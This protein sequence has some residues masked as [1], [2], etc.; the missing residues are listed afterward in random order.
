MKT[1]VRIV[2]CCT[3][4]MSYAGLSLAGQFVVLKSMISS[5]GESAIDSEMGK[6]SPPDTKPFWTQRKYTAPALHAGDS[7]ALIGARAPYC[8]PAPERL[9]HQAPV[10]T[11]LISHFPYPPFWPRDPS[12]A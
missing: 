6:S 2:V 11:M 12:L 7:S 5:G 8:P 1:I 3:L 9:L 10:Y 4:V